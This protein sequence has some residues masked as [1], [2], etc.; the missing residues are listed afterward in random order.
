MK[1]IVSCLLL[2]SVLVS[3][4][5]CSNT[6]GGTTLEESLR[7]SFG[8]MY[9]GLESGILLDGSTDSYWK[10]NDGTITLFGDGAF[11]S[12]AAGSFPW[13]NVS[14]HIVKLH[15]SGGVTSLGSY[16]FCGYDRLTTVEVEDGALF[17]MGMG[18]FSD[19]QNLKTVDLGNTLKKIPSEAFLGCASLEE[20]YIPATV[21]LIE[22]HAFKD[23][24]ALKC[25]R[26]GGS[27]SDWNALTIEEG[28]EILGR[29]E[30][31]FND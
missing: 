15:I 11:I 2:I 22:D 7:E 27:E 30:I 31:I 24:E 29:A 19:C 6:Q 26:F 28:N 21:T 9:D 4:G 5:S 25:V 23:C 10:L 18:C 13:R 3:A 20:I 1:K 17:G 14:E 12:T 16:A 8:D